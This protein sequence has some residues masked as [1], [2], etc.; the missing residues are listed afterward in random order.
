MSFPLFTLFFFISLS[1]PRPCKNVLECSRVSN[2]F[3]KYFCPDFRFSK[4]LQVWFLLFC[5]QVF[6]RTYLVLI[7]G[8]VHPLRVM[9]CP[10]WDFMHSR[11]LLSVLEFSSVLVFSEFLQN[12]FVQTFDFLNSSKSD[13]Y[14]SVL[15]C[16]QN[17]SLILIQGRMHPFRVMY[18][19]L[20]YFLCS[21]TFFRS[22]VLCVLVFSKFLQTILFQTFWFLRTLWRALLFS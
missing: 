9:Y 3:A 8:C 1:P 2:F 21:R 16:S 6:S 13:F 5:S 12:I 19:P 17:T 20:L 7:Q 18:R 4:F 14:F 15:K 22:R 10:L 11:T